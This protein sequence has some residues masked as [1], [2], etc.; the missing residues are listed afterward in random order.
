MRFKQS[1]L[2]TIIAALST[3]VLV[4]LLRVVSSELRIFAYFQNYIYASALF[5]FGVGVINARL[6]R[7]RTFTN[8]W[9]L[10]FGV[11]LVLLVGAH[12]SFVSNL[13]IL[14]ES[15]SFFYYPKFL[16]D[17]FVHEVTSTAIVFV[18]FLITA[19]IFRSLGNEFGRLVEPLPPLPSLFRLLLG[20]AGG[21]LLAGTL[22]GVGAPPVVL[23]AVIAAAAYLLGGRSATALSNLPV[24]LMAA[25]ALV[26][27]FSFSTAVRPE[28]L[29]KITSPSVAATSNFWRPYYHVETFPVTFQ[30]KTLGQAICGNHNPL[31]FILDMNMN[32]QEAE[33]LSSSCEALTGYSTD[34]FDLIYKVVERPA[35][36]L[37]LGSGAG[38]EVVAALRHG[39][40]HVDAVDP[41]ASMFEIGNLHP[42]KPYSSP[43]VRRIAADPRQYLRN[44]AEKYDLILF[45]NLESQ[46]AFGPFGVLRT[47]N[48][49]YT[50]DSFVD[51]RMHLKP[52]GYAAISFIPIRGWL[53]MRLAHNSI[54]AF[55]KID[56]ELRGLYRNIIIEGRDQNELL[57]GTLL[58]KLGPNLV[59]D[60]AT[61]SENCVDTFPSYDNWPFVFAQV[62]SIPRTYLYC[63]TL[64][65]LAMML[66]SRSLGIRREDEPVVVMTVENLQIALLGGALFL[67][68]DKAAMT[69]AYN[70]GC[71][72]DVLVNS[73]V[74]TTL[75]MLIALVLC[76][77]KFSIPGWLFWPMA[78]GLIL[79][80]AI[81]INYQ[82]VSYIDNV[83]LRFLASAIVPLIPTFILALAVGR[84]IKAVELG[85]I[86]VGMFCCGA[87]IGAVFE[88]L[89][90]LAGVSFL[91][92][93]AILTCLV[94][95]ALGI[96]FNKKDVAVAQTG[97]VS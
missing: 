54:V 83:A 81:L 23:V 40:A 74:S 60:N 13:G 96:R 41:D 75:V 66:C 47:D 57:G 21:W 59:V 78:I 38:N 53:G 82:A 65:M 91:D 7:F 80:E 32:S 77:R 73:A 12:F 6:Q 16:K 43:L 56:A 9:F 51:A 20:M 28:A 84:R 42:Q 68:Q 67:L 55:D 10:Y 2:A 30:G 3:I 46:T 8:E 35:N 92:I 44:T 18:V 93:V 85:L 5:G 36:V 95:L 33:S 94:A 62:P 76:N 90:F 88:S 17:L 52:H 58:Q 69:F 49:I 61:L 97:S 14:K 70:F 48:F 25:V 79:S 22:I 15:T 86:P 11:L 27:S 50:L 19:V 71:T 26:S 39:A 29:E 37:I 45:A 31:Q 24:L 64:L 72:W 63:I 87:G 1:H 4:T 89:D 34:Y